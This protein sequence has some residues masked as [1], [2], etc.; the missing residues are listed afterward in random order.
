MLQDLQ[1]K[2]LKVD[3]QINIEKTEVMTNNKIQQNNNIRLKGKLI[4]FA[5]NY[6]Y[7]GQNTNHKDTNQDKETQRRIQL[8]WR[9]FG[10][11][12]YIFKSEL[13]EKKSFQH[14]YHSNDD[15]WSRD[16]DTDKKHNTETKSHSESNRKK[17]AWHDKEG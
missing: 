5:K 7:L 15:L 16:L 8:G 17:H 14:L 3:L 10:R 6:V 9:A 13:P 4:E 11:L 1:S 2:S 12:N